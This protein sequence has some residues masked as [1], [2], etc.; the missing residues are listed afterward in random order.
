MNALRVVASARVESLLP[1][2]LRQHPALVRLRAS[3]LAQR[4]ARESV[5]AVCDRL[6]TPVG[7]ASDVPAAT[8]AAAGV[9]PS[10]D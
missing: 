5:E 1:R 4:P 7:D 8:G 3:L 6:L 10:T 2:S 9:S